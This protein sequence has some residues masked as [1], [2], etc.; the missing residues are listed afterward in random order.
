MSAKEFA[1]QEV[2]DK[3]YKGIKNNLD[4][5]VDEND[6][7][8]LWLEKFLSGQSSHKKKVF[9]I[10]CFPGSY[11]YHFGKHKY[12]LNGIDITDE[13]DESFNNWLQSKGFSV[14][15]IYKQD[16]FSFEPTIKY[17][18]VCSFGFIEHFSNFTE[19]IEKHIDWTKPGGHIII[20]V[21]DFAN[22]VQNFLHRY[23]DKQLLN[24]HNLKAM[25][26]RAWEKAFACKN[27][28]VIFKG[29]FGGFTYWAGNQKRN[30]IQKLFVKTGY[31]MSKLFSNVERSS[32]LY[33]PFMGIIL[34]K[35]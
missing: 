17:D 21:P 9:E 27:V 3:E 6:K 14:G 23:S 19:L 1:P 25:N 24:I 11:L 33:S 32:N 18:I 28:E 8:S 5:Y 10:G 20:T 30:F 12:E 26:M 35:Y 4:N 13:M 2:W 15:E 16:V 34:K 22:S 31:V 29:H 7:V